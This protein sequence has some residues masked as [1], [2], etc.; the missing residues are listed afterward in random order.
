MGLPVEELQRV[1]GGKRVDEEAADPVKLALL[2]PPPL[3][4]VHPGV[5]L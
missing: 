3:E 4:I 5:L 1:A 2:L